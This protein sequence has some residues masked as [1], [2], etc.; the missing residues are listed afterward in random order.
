MP[1]SNIGNVTKRANFMVE[2]KF[3]TVDND[4]AEGREHGRISFTILHMYARSDRLDQ[5]TGHPKVV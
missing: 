1:D 4:L 5:L 3:P 2:D